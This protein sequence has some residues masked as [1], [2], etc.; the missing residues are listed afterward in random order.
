MQQP[1]SAS[2][3]IPANRN[4]VFRDR[5]GLLHGQTGVPAFLIFLSSIDRQFRL[6]LRGAEEVRGLMANANPW[7]KRL[8]GT[9]GS[10]FLAGGKRMT[11]LLE[12]L[13]EGGQA[14]LMGRDGAPGK[15]RG[16]YRFLDVADRAD[17]FYVPGL[18]TLGQTVDPSSVF[19]MMERLDQICERL[20]SPLAVVD[21]TH[22]SRPFVDDMAC[23]RTLGV[24]EEI[25]TEFGLVPSGGA[26]CAYF[27]QSDVDAGLQELPSGITRRVPVQV[28]QPEVARRE[29]LKAGGRYWSWAQDSS[30]LQLL[31]NRVLGAKRPSVL[32]GTKSVLS[33]EEIVSVRRTLGAVT[34][35]IRQTCEPFVLEPADSELVVRVET[36][37]HNLFEQ[38]RK[39]FQADSAAPVDLDVDFRWEK[40]EGLLSVDVSV[41]L[42]R[43][44]E[45]LGVSVEIC[46]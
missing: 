27:Q 22:A 11:L 33:P 18:L 8:L 1:V 15:R 16:L 12:P 46:A 40:G 30:G 45:R 24:A 4:S 31:G 21:L 2:V 38:H 5:V 20:E 6:E 39:L 25:G 7:E 35:A 14:G 36:A 10:F 37:L 42:P 41:A 29:F 3:E 17:L 43:V 19:P 23:T 9:V 28:V 34:V 26:A 32:E 13:A 44:I